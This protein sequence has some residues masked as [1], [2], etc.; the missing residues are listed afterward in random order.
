M[1]IQIRD[2]EAQSRKFTNV[3]VQR[4]VSEKRDKRFSS[5]ASN[6]PKDSANLALR[7][8]QSEKTRPESTQERYHSKAFPSNFQ[9]RGSEVG[10][11]CYIADVVCTQGKFYAECPLLERL[12][13][14]AEGFRTPNVPRN[15]LFTMPDLRQHRCLT[16][17]GF[18]QLETNDSDCQ[19]DN[20]R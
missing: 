5:S 20:E 2:V 7:D 17:G 12:C 13:I 18:P 10:L 11:A 1:L 4:W 9:V 16:P 3:P 8:F 14:A 15:I 19:A 6:G